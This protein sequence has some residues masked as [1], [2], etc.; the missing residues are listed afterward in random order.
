[1]K[2]Q[3]DSYDETVFE[4]LKSMKTPREIANQQLSSGSMPD[5]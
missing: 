5:A 4:T 2:I 3:T 1:M